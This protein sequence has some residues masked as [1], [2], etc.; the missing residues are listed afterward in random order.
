MTTLP[1]EGQ[2]IVGRREMVVLPELELTLCAKIDTG[3]RTSALHAE[4]IETFVQDG[5][6]W[7]RF[8]TRVDG[9]D[10]PACPCT[11]HLHDRRRITSS[12]GQT[13][14]RCVVSTLMLLG[15]KQMPIQ[16]TL[17]DRG[18]M[19]YPMLLGRRAL[20]DML[21]APSQVFLHGRP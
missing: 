16:L 13:E 20:G 12:N 6:P 19:R 15:D 4:D 7:V 8:I 5:Q 14:W 9:P 3:A 11:L 1:Y 10:S 18:Q 2:I 17:T 21:V